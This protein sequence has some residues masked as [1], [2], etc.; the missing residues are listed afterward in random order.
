MKRVRA[1]TMH[2]SWPKNGG[3][4]GRGVKVVQR[5]AYGPRLAGQLARSGWLVRFLLSCS[6]SKQHRFGALTLFF[7]TAFFKKE[8][9]FFWPL[10]CL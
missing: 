5:M 2:V 8:K 7:L 10:D 1:H 6:A 3:E 4:R 9:S